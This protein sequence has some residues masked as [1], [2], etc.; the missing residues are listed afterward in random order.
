MI[1]THTQVRD[2]LEL[3]TRTKQFSNA[4]AYV[5]NG[6]WCKPNKKQTTRTHTHDKL[7]V[8]TMLVNLIG[9]THGN[10]NLA[11]RCCAY[12]CTHAYTH[13]RAHT[14]HTHIRAR[15]RTHTHTHTTTHTRTRTHTHIH[16]RTHSHAH[17]LCRFICIDW[18][19]LRSVA[20]VCMCACVCVR[21]YVCACV[22]EDTSIDLGMNFNSSRRCVCVC[23]CVYGCVGCVFVCVC[24]QL[25]G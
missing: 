8:V 21:V 11:I 15:T 14:T 7:S 13:T 22:S 24:V 6:K 5:A 3:L 25:D 12:T 9:I 23:T 17:N 18:L 4:F 1:T 19:L 20:C 16:I 10:S 2:V